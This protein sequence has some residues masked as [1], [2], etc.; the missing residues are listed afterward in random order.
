MTRDEVTRKIRAAKRAESLR[1][2]TI[3]AGIGARRF[4]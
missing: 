1:W 4:I 2:M 3:V